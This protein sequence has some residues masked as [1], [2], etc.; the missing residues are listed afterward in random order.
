[1]LLILKVYLRFVIRQ[2]NCFIMKCPCKNLTSTAM[3]IWTYH[4]TIKKMNYK[5]MK[6]KHFFVLLVI[7]FVISCR[8]NKSKADKIVKE[9][10]G[11]EILIPDSGFT[12]NV[13][14]RD[15]TC[16]DLWNKPYKIL[17]YIDS[18]GCSA[19]QMGLNNWRV[20]IDSCEQLQL[21]VS[22]LFG[23]RKNRHFFPRLV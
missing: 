5:Q 15:T 8:N 22:F 18:V 23:N 16:I 9:W 21:D 11:K 6:L 12:Y 19:C 14:G 17:T 20:L 4:L 2:N 3:N 1:M 10:Q 7:V 13:L